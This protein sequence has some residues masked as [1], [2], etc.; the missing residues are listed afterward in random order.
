MTKCL[1]REPWTCKPEPRTH[2][3][4]KVKRTDEVTSQRYLALVTLKAP[5][6]LSNTAR[7]GLKSY[8]HTTRQPT[9][10]KPISPSRTW[11]AAGAKGRPHGLSSRLPKKTAADGMAHV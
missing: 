3:R 6:N 7:I 1:V 8:L 11:P 9:D 4:A 5:Q 2:G 10:D